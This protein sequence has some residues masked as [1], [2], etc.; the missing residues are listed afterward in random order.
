MTPTQD[1]YHRIKVLIAQG[2]TDALDIVAE[3]QIEPLFR[4]LVTTRPLNSETIFK[5]HGKDA[6]VQYIEICN[7]IEGVEFDNEL[8]DHIATIQ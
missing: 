2:D 6:V 1:L 7:F 5:K 8:Q 3:L 4:D